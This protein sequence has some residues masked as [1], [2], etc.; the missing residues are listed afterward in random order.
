MSNRIR[1]QTCPTTDTRGNMHTRS[2]ALVQVA[3]C[4]ACM[5]Q[6]A[7]FGAIVHAACA[8]LSDPMPLTRRLTEVGVL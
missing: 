7:R 3:Y 6:L 4:P 2:V 5:G 1:C 8:E